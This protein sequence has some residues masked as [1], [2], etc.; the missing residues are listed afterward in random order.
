MVAGLLKSL[1]ANLQNVAH[2][3][4]FPTVPLPTWSKPKP[5]S[6][7]LQTRLRPLET[8]NEKD[9]FGLPSF[10]DPDP[11][12]VLALEKAG[13]DIREAGTQSRPSSDAF[14]YKPSPTSPIFSAFARHS[15]QSIDS[16]SR[17][18]SHR[19]SHRSTQS[20][21]QGTQTADL[22]IQTIDEIPQGS[23]SPAKKTTEDLAWISDDED[24]IEEEPETYIEEAAPTVHIIAHS[25]PSPTVTRVKLVTIQKRIPPALPPR[26][27]YRQRVSKTTTEQPTSEPQQ[28]ESSE[29]DHSSHYSSPTRNE[30]DHDSITSPN[31]W[32]EVSL[33]PDFEQRSTTMLSDLRTTDSGNA[34]EELAQKK[35]V[36]ETTST[37]VEDLA[38]GKGTVDNNEILPVLE[39]SIVVTQQSPSNA[40]KL[41]NEGEEFHSMPSTPLETPSISLREVTEDFS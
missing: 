33:T 29:Y 24:H 10:D 4:P 36:D 15:M 38:G 40:E 20:V 8:L 16:V 6:S 11:F 17:Q 9:G 34:T 32:E 23:N 2:T 22:G 30:F 31:P 3:M 1:N 14:E 21:D 26:N 37:N 28:D 39:D 7:S 25:M 19:H 5:R 35:E 41:A 27:P 18:S 13:L 12:G